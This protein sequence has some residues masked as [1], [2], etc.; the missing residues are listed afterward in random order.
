MYMIQYS[1]SRD[2]HLD[3]INMQRLI[4]KRI[5][6]LITEETLLPSPLDEETPLPS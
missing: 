5:D 1:H 6:V 4:K 3:G 2:E